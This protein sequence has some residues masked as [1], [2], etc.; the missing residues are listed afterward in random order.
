M[1]KIEN[2]IVVVFIKIYLKKKVCFRLILKIKKNIY[3][4][5]I[6]LSY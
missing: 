4:I 6:Y 3:L 2:G 1:N 5:I